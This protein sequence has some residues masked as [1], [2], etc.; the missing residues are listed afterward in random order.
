MSII[1]WIQRPKVRG[2][3]SVLNCRLTAGYLHMCAVKEQKPGGRVRRQMYRAEIAPRCCPSVIFPDSVTE[4]FYPLISLDMKRQEAPAWWDKV[5][6]VLLLRV[7][8]VSYLRFSPHMLR[9]KLCCTRA[10]GVCASLCDPRRWEPQKLK[11]DKRINEMV[12]TT[13][14][15][16]F[17]FKNQK[18]NCNDSPVIKNKSL[19]ILL[20]RNERKTKNLL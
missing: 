4:S 15:F 9:L 11:W 14:E 13:T 8:L 19:L 6:A 10:P 3:R 17:L 1:H 20:G 16:F 18:E 12:S 2:I 5:V 7:R